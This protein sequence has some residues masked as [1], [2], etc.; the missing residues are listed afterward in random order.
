MKIHYLSDIH[1]DHF[2]SETSNPRQIQRQLDDFFRY[3]K[4]DKLIELPESERNIFIIPGDCS[5]YNSVAKHFLLRLKEIF[6]YIIIVPG[7]HDM[8]LCTSSQASKY[9]YQSQNRIQDMKEFCKNNN[10]YYLDGDIVEISGKKFAGLGMFWDKFYYNKL[11]KRE[12]S[13]NEVLNFYDNYMNDS[14]FIMSGHESMKIPLTYG[15]SFLKTS[16]NALEHFEKE[17]QKLQRFNDFD[18]IDVMITHYVPT[19]PYGMKNKYAMERGTTF[20]MFDGEKDIERISPKFWLFGHMHD[21]YDFIHKDVR[22]LCNPSG[23]PGETPYSVD[24]FEV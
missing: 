3:S 10:I 17:Y 4:I 13:D 8:Y 9:K 12:A 22:F 11:E 18:D 6:K 20:Y 24:W 2:V 16:F 14:K 19:I 15:G 1:I 21:K 5:N 23:Y 7:N